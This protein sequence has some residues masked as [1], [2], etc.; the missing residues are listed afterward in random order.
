MEKEIVKETNV[1]EKRETASDCRS[2][3]W[4]YGI[5]PECGAPLGVR[6]NRHCVI[7]GYRCTRCDFL[8]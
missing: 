3:F 2:E 6:T 7:I 4:G 1:D 8:T 5:C